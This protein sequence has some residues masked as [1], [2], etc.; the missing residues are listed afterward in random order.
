M[1][2]PTVGLTVSKKVGNLNVGVTYS[3]YKQVKLFDAPAGGQSGLTHL[4][5]L[6]TVSL[7]VGYDF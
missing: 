2:T 5:G 7:R 6:Q 4:T 3:A 1:F